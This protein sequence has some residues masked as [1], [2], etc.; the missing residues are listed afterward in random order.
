MNLSELKNIDLKNIDVKDLVEKLKNNDLL[1]DKKFLTKF[2][3]YFGSPFYK[4]ISE[5]SLIEHPKRQSSL[6]FC[7]PTNKGA[8]VLITK[9]ILYKSIKYKVNRF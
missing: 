6:G 2:G 9:H 3:I 5:I 8:F 4:N 1:K 7:I